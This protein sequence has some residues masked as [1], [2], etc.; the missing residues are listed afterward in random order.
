[1]QYMFMWMRLCVHISAR[2]Q[3]EWHVAWDNLTVEVLSNYF[4]VRKARR[5]QTILPSGFYTIT[6]LWRISTGDDMSTGTRQ[7]RQAPLSRQAVI[8][9]EPSPPSQGAHYGS[10]AG[11]TSCWEPVGFRQKLVRDKW[12]FPGHWGMCATETESGFPKE[13]TFHQCSQSLPAFLLS[14]HSFT[15]IS[16]LPFLHSFCFSFFF[17]SLPPSLSCRPSLLFPHMVVF[18]GYSHLSVQEEEHVI[19]VMEMWSSALKHALQFIELFLW[20]SFP[21]FIG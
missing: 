18:R 21:L 13:H 9:F 14:F 10:P 4:H 15:S 1:M 7:V 16:F 20:P 6:T 19:P 2:Q 12:V 17:L 11:P 5:N 3:Q 8:P